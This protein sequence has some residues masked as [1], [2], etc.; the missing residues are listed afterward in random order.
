MLSGK[1]ILVAED[2][3][4]IAAELVRM[5]ADHRGTALGPA[6]T[7]V[8]ALALLDE[9]PDGAILDGNLLDGPVTPVARALCDKSVPLVVFTG[10]GLPADLQRSHP[11]IPVILKPSPYETVIHAIAE[12]VRACPPPGA[13][14]EN[15]PGIGLVSPLR[16]A[17][18]CFPAAESVGSDFCL[19]DPTGHR[20]QGHQRR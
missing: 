5:I 17:E 4:W 7:N 15:M 3:D 19:N 12:R 20:N 18:E 16:L 11:D 9:H 6:R 8:E 1:R 10:L 2:N 14:A 13:R